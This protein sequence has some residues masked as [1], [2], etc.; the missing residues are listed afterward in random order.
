[1]GLPKNICDD[2]FWQADN[3]RQILYLAFVYV[4]DS[5]RGIYCFLCTL[6]N[7]KDFFVH[8]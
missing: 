6:T 4:S 5:V 7:N 3:N 1:M 8:S 2:V